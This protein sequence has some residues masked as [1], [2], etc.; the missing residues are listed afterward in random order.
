[1]NQQQFFKAVLIGNL[2]KVKQYHGNITVNNNFALLSA[3]GEGHL[4]IV[5]Y[6]IEN[7]ADV[8]AQENEPLMFAS[9]NG[10][11]DVVQFLI[12]KGAKVTDQNNEALVCAVENEH[13]DVIKCLL[14][15]GATPPHKKITTKIKELGI[16]LKFYRVSFPDVKVAK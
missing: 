14:E 2:E 1:M 7:G 5:Q 12:K 4:N 8:Q 11:L 10:H 13:L 15:N 16:D 9:I 6:L 3:L